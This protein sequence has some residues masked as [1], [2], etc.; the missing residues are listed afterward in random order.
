MGSQSRRPDPG[1]LEAGPIIRR[2]ARTI[3]TDLSRRSCWSTVLRPRWRAL[4]GSRFAF[5]ARIGDRT[6]LTISRWLRTLWWT[7]GCYR[8]TMSKWYKRS[9]LRLCGRTPRGRK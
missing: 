6:Y 8:R 2:V 3:G 4:Y 5:V 7:L 9:L 1:S